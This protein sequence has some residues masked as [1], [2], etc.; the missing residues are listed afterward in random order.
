MFKK[1]NMVGDVDFCGG[2]IIG[3]VSFIGGHVAKK[4][5]R[6]GFRYGFVMSNVT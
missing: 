3:A 2:G 4:N 5:T 6:S 1:A